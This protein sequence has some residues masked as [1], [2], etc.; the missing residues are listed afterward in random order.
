MFLKHFLLDLCLPQSCEILLLNQ[1][2]LKFMMFFVGKELTF[3]LFHCYIIIMKD[4]G[5]NRFLPND[6]FAS[7][8]S[9]M[10][11]SQNVFACKFILVGLKKFT[12]L[13]Y[14]YLKSLIFCFLFSEHRGER[15][16]G[17]FPAAAGGSEGWGPLCPEL[18]R[19]HVHR[20]QPHHLHQR[21][22]PVRQLLLRLQLW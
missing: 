21:A 2:I 12:T 14:F 15:S 17:G 16:P 18:R 11:K 8:M 20:H 3:T 19:P 7:M 4:I 13:W 22:P 9:S 5:D 1:L 6:K 10:W